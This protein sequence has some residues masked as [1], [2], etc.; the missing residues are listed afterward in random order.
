M[1]AVGK[2][3]EEKNEPQ[4]GVNHFDSMDLMERKA[5]VYRFRGQIDKAIQFCRMALESRMRLQGSNDPKTMDTADFLRQ[6]EDER[7]E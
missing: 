1:S 6:L 4:G 3:F 7:N 5:L 2:V